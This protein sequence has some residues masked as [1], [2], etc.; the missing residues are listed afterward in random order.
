VDG[1]ANGWV[2]LISLREIFLFCSY[3]AKFTKTLPINFYK[4]SENA[5]M[6][7][8]ECVQNSKISKL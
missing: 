3:E 2:G 7:L 1:W 4:L 6:T 5:E 8:C